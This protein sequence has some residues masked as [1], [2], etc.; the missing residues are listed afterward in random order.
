MGKSS[1]HPT[2]YC[3]VLPFP[4]LGPELPQIGQTGTSVYST[5]PL[6]SEY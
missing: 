4:K 2:E 6:H 3:V 1:L 5:L